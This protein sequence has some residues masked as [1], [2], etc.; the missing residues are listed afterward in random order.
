[1]IGAFNCQGAGWDSKE[2]RLRGFPE[3][4]K[5]MCGSVHVS[6]IEWDQKAEAAQMGKAEEYIVY[7]SQAGE[8][9]LMTP[10]SEPMQITIQPSAFE[11]F[12]F[13]PVEKLGGTVKFAPIGLTNMFNSGGTIQEVGYNETGAKIKVKGGGNLLAY[14]SE[15]PRKAELNGAE[16]GF[17]WSTDGKLA[18]SLPWNDASG[19]VSDVAFLFKD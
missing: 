2:H 3:C 17:E 18:L 6:E 7:L 16:V 19:G 10:K 13:V 5:P 12:F 1:M 11:L 8:L 4:Y 9:R 15:S 14:S